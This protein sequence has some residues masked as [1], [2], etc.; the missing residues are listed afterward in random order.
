MAILEPFEPWGFNDTEGGM[1]LAERVLR[2]VRE[3]DA[4][5]GGR[6]VPRDYPRLH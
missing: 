4:E 6:Q 5:S 2:F 1:R 3:V